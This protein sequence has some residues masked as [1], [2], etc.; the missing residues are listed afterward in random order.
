MDTQ[1]QFSVVIPVYNNAR[2]IKSLCQSLED[3]LS[4]ITLCYEIILVN[5]YSSDNSWE[6]MQQI[7]CNQPKI[8]LV[9]N[10]KNLGQHHSILLG[11]QK[12]NGKKIIVMDADLQD[13]PEYIPGLA[14]KS[15][16]GYDLVFIKR[17]GHYQN[18]IRMVGS[19]IFKSILSS[20]TGVHYKAG[21]YFLFNR[22]LL[23]KILAYDS[24]FPYITV[25]ISHFAHRIDYIEG[26]RLKRMTSK[27]SYSFFG[28]L[29]YAWHAI[30]C[31]LSLQNT[32]N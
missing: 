18:P 29:K 3:N 22:E 17:A 6:A 9:N 26:R 23:P 32:P 14:E 11:L 24:K 25:I 5:D 27:S 12:A 2:E 15:E 21:S 4:K 1:T 7:Q 30:R 31:K 13:Q 28:R 10:P 16:E 8:I 20:I 19:V